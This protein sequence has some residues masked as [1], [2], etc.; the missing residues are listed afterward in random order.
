MGSRLQSKGAAVA[1]VAVVKAIEKAETRDAIKS[2]ENQWHANSAKILSE[3][4]CGKPYAKIIDWER[5]G[6]GTPQKH[7]RTCQATA[8]QA[9]VLVQ[10]KVKSAGLRSRARIGEQSSRQRLAAYCQA[11]YDLDTR[12]TVPER[13]LNTWH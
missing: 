10:H 13:P 2:G 12:A 8:K 4:E 5:S 3:S 1:E 9:I 6:K 7:G 11:E